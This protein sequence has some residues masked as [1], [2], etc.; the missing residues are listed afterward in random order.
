ATRDPGSVGLANVRKYISYG[1]S[2]RASIN[3]MLAS[4][5]L[6]YIRGRDYVLPADVLDL[7][8]DVFRHRLVLSYEALSEEITADAVLNRVLRAVRMPE[9]RPHAVVS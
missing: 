2:P 3:L 5:A 9:V 1:A 8:H 4:R 6:A 7:V